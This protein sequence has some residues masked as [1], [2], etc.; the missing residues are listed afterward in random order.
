MLVRRSVASATRTQETSRSSTCFKCIQSTSIHRQPEAHVR[1]IANRTLPGISYFRKC[2]HK[3]AE[4]YKTQ[5][6]KLLHHFLHNHNDIHQHST[7]YTSTVDIG[8]KVIGYS[9]KPAILIQNENIK[10][11]TRKSQSNYHYN[12]YIGYSDKSAIRIQ[13][14]HSNHLFV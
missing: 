1:R 7:S 10:S 12:Q 6:K 11:K 2:K 4:T 8:Y 3:N 14:H 13:N 9:D 5:P